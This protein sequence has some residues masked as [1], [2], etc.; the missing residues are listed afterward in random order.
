FQLGFTWATQ[1]DT[2]LL[3]LQVSPAA[4]Q[5]C[6]QVVQLGQFDLQLALMGT[7]ALGENIQDQ[8]GTVDD[9][10]FQLTL[11]VALLARCQ[12]MVEDDQVTFA[13]LDQSPQLFHLAGADK[14]TGTG[15]IAGNGQEID[16]FRPG[17]THQLQKLMSVFTDLFILAFKMNEH[18]PVTTRVTFKNQ[19]P[20]PCGQG[21]PASASSAPCTGRRTGRPG[22]TVEIA[23]L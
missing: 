20:L 17:R 15:L 19:S 14:K 4:H 21:L 16:N 5:A 13:C 7:G 18:R 22:T 10:A 6:T 23:C 9:A 2:A 3:P 11:E 8:T 12:H 1:A